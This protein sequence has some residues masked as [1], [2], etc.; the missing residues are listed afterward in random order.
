[1]TSDAAAG[2]VDE[3]LGKF[4]DMLASDGYSLSWSLTDQDKV[5]VQ[6]EAGPEACEDCLVPLPIM[7]AIMSDALGPTPYAL[8]HV[9][10]P[11]DGGH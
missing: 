6:I 7:E 3:A 10:L 1:M 5:V 8:D 4:R 2:T 9:V 11:A